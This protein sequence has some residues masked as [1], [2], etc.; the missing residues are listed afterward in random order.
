MSK[1]LE[2]LHKIMVAFGTGSLVETNDCFVIDKERYNYG[3][4]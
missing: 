4:D 1:G 2:T 3:N